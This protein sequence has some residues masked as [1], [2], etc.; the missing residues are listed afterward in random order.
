MALKDVYLVVNHAVYGALYR[1][2][3]QDVY[4]A[5]HQAMAL[6]MARDVDLAVLDAVHRAVIEVGAQFEEFPHPGLKLYL[7]SVT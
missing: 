3:Y 2:V 5:V 1:D 7:G 6:T 4:L